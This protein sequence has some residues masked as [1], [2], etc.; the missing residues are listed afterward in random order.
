MMGTIVITI[1]I[2]TLGCQKAR[3]GLMNLMNTL[4]GKVTTSDTSLVGDDN[5]RDMNPIKLA[6]GLD[7][8]RY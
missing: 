8:T 6:N 4:L 3:E 7:R 5:N 2:S 1:Y